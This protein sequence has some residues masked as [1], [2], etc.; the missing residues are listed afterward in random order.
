MIQDIMLNL[1]CDKNYYALRELTSTKSSFT[2]NDTMN[3]ILDTQQ[4]DHILHGKTMDS[5]GISTDGKLDNGDDQTIT[6]RNGESVLN[7]CAYYVMMIGTEDQLVYDNLIRI[8]IKSFTGNAFDITVQMAVHLVSI[9]HEL[10]WLSALSSCPIDSLLA[11][12]HGEQLL[13]DKETT[14]EDKVI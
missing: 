2:T 7:S 6:A 12:K 10:H 5:I 8:R 4:C 1:R 3:H 9:R 14:Y 11:Y 13:A